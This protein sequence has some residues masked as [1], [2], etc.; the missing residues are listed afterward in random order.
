MTQLTGL[1]VTLPHRL[2]YVQK[3]LRDTTP[4]DAPVKT[5]ESVILF[6]NLREAEAI[7][8]T[9]P[10]AVIRHV[11]CDVIITSKCELRRTELGFECPGGLPEL[12]IMP[13]VNMSLELS[14]D[15]GADSD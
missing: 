6:E 2:Y 14:D 3:C 13:V 8:R 12:A 7:R 10:N 4:E 9:Y 1:D 5:N 11:M 15:S